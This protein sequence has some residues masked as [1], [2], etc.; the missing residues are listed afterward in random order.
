MG[1]GEAG[2]DLSRFTALLNNNNKLVHGR[3]GQ[4]WNISTNGK[5]AGTRV[6]NQQLELCH[7]SQ[8]LKIGVQGSI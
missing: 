8:V 2:T 4:A 1:D 7:V 6:T 3:S 5:Q